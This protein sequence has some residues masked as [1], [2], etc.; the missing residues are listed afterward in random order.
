MFALLFLTGGQIHEACA[1]QILMMKLT[2]VKFVGFVRVRV[3]LFDRWSNACVLPR[4]NSC[5]FDM[6]LTTGQFHSFVRIRPVAR[7][8]SFVHTFSAKIPMLDLTENRSM[9]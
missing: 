1:D 9:P 4:S 7:S 2:V 5:E 3:A 6:N 8:V